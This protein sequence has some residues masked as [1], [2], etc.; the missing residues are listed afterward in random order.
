MVRDCRHTACIGLRD[1]EHATGD[2]QGLV[3]YMQQEMVIDCKHTRGKGHRHADILQGMVRDYRLLQGKWS[4][5][6]Y[7]IYDLVS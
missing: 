5:T 4:K 1:Y 7:M 3:K 6:V 2:G